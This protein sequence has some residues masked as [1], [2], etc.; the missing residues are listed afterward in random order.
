MEPVKTNQKNNRLS[1][2]LIVMAM[3]EEYNILRC[4]FLSILPHPSCL[5]PSYSCPLPPFLP[6]SSS[7]L[8]LF[9]LF[10]FSLSLIRYTASNYMLRS[11]SWLPSLF[12]S[13][14]HTVSGTNMNRIPIDIVLNSNKSKNLKC[15]LT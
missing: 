2:D 15:Y 11:F 14:P 6:Y 10:Y 9:L 7:P 4:L 12:N 1:L 13:L 3:I 5:P 8:P